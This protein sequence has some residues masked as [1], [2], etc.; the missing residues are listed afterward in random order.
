M[1]FAKQRNDAHN[2][3]KPPTLNNVYGTFSTQFLSHKHNPTHTHP[4]RVHCQFQYK[5][6][7][8]IHIIILELIIRN[9]K[10][11]TN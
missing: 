5:I 8:Y 3:Q 1:Q 6:I 10:L 7:N 9:P 11:I 2:T 4:V